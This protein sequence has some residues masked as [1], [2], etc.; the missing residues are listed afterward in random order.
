MVGLGRIGSQL[1]SADLAAC[2]NYAQ[3]ARESQ[4]TSLALGVDPDAGQRRLFEAQHGAP[5]LASLDEAARQGFL[6]DLWIVACPSL[7]LVGVV[8]DVFRLFPKSHVLVEKPVAVTEQDIG[9]CRQWPA[10]R[11]RVGYTRRFIPESSRLREVIEGESLGLL[12][13][14]RCVYSRGFANNASHLINLLQFLAGDVCLD[15]WTRLDAWSPSGDCS[16][17]AVGRIALRQHPDQ[18]AELLVSC[19]D[20]PGSTVAEMVL[21]FEFGKVKYEDLGARVTIHRAH[22]E[23]IQLTTDMGR[24]MCTVMDQL[25]LWVSGKEARGCT[26]EEAL[27]TSALLKRAVEQ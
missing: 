24:A 21:D 5:S 1:G 9:R 16:I 23:E 17:D 26:L 22:G 15:R 4:A 10:K 11:V 3:A 6:P 12:K 14:V 20:E 7:Q 2:A 18:E 8:S 25:S 13:S 19:I 27:E